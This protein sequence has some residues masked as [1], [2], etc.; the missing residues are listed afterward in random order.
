[1][2][3][4]LMRAIEAASDALYRGSVPATTPEQRRA[5]A[6]ALLAEQ[7]LAVGFSADESAGGDVQPDAQLDVSAETRST[8]LRAPK[9]PDRQCGSERYLVVLHVDEAT[10]TAEREPGRSELEDGTRASAET[11][12]RVACDASVLRVVSGPEAAD[13]KAEGKTRTV[14][15]R[16]RRALEVRDRGCKFPGCGSRFTDAHHIRHW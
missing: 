10:L 3:A 4:L 14:P 16:L 1:M 11:S 12:R 6:L 15:S 2:G 9:A 13:V 5:D 8:C 7:A